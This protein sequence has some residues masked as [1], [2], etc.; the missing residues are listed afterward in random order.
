VEVELVDAAGEVDLTTVDKIEVFEVNHVKQC[1]TDPAEVLEPQVEVSDA[2]E[3]G[4]S[5]AP[6]DLGDDPRLMIRMTEDQVQCPV[7]VDVCPEE[8]SHAVNRDSNV[9]SLWGCVGKLTIGPSHVGL[10]AGEPAVG[11]IGAGGID[12]GTACAAEELALFQPFQAW[13][14]LPLLPC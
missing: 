6:R 13:L 14:G 8:T 7:G 2:L 1:T 11:W 4:P 9:G 10:Q 12:V 5:G 3:R